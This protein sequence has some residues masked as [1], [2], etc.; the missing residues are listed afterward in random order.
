MIRE[1]RILVNF[2][3]K[4]LGLHLFCD[5]IA[6]ESYH[7]YLRGWGHLHVVSHHLVTVPNH[8]VTSVTPTNYVNP[9]LGFWVRIYW[10]LI[11]NSC[12]L[13][14]L[15]FMTLWQGLGSV[16]RHYFMPSS[17]NIERNKTDHGY[18]FIA[19]NWPTF[20]RLVGSSSALVTKPPGSTD[21]F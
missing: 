12:A 15:K 18:V 13:L 11:L 16:S 1:N 3:I 7:G 8:T 21:I 20:L 5:A 17:E 4:R 14:F 9:W 10:M 19:Y 2:H 6:K